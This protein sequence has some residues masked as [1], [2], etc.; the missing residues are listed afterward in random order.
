MKKQLYFYVFEVL[1]YLRD[2][3]FLSW[4]FYKHLRILNAP[5]C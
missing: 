2:Y 5:K 1:I 3:L 4:S